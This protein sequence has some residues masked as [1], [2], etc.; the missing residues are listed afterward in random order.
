M[1]QQ[2]IIKIILITAFIAFALALFNSARSARS[3][4][5]RTIGI[6]CFLLCVIFAVIFPGAVN[7]LATA[8]GVGRGTD[9][10]LYAFVVAFIGIALATTRRDR[11]Q[12]RKITA[13]ARHLA[14]L[15][16][17]RPEHKE[18]AGS[19]GESTSGDN[20][21]IAPATDSTA[22]KHNSV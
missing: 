18:N 10:L 2:I 3:Q 21:T 14:V 8:V 12:E 9:L 19:S 11:E 16:T 1:E 20:L 17:V 7:D 22:Q 4:A 5:L 15:S 13:I 6:I